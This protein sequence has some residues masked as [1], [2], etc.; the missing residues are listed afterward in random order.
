MKLFILLTTLISFNSFAQ[1][2]KETTIKGA[3]FVCSDNGGAIFVSIPG[4]KIWLADT[5][6]DKTGIEFSMSKLSILR[7]PNCYDFEAEMI[8]D[9]E[10]EGKMVYTVRA[11]AG[12]FSKFDLT[13]QAFDS[14]GDQSGDKHTKPCK[15]LN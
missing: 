4:K 1:D 9:G 13:L 10:V 12:S 11:A 5:V 3:G 2:L 8:Q 7:C 15:K 6:K 14:Y